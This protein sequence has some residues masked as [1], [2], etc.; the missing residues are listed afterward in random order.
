MGFDVFTHGII[1][2]TKAEKIIKTLKA[3]QLLM[4]AYDVEHVKACGTC[5]S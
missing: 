2:D 1:A 3:Y 5:T 4:D